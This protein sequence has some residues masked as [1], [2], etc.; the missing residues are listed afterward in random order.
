MPIPTLPIIA[1]LTLN[2]ALDFASAT[3]RVLHTDKLR[4]EAGRYDPGGGGL[5]VARVVTTL[6]GA[7]TAIYPVG[8]PTGEML[9]RLVDAIGIPQIAIPIAGET[10]ISF[11]VSERSSGN[12]YRFVLPGPHLT[13]E[14]QD[15][16]L[17]ALAMMK[18]RLA[19][20]VVSGSLPPGVGRD[21][22]V[23]VGRLAAQ[24]G[25][26]LFLDTSGPA[27]AAAAGIGAYLVKPNLRE[28][29]AFVDR[30]LQ[31]SREQITAGREMLDRLGA[32]VVIVSL[33]ADGALIVTADD[34]ECLPTPAVTIRS[35]VGAGDSM[36]G[37]IATRLVGGASLR[38]AA[39]YGLAAGAAALLTDG[40]EL[41]RRDDTDRLY[42]A[43][44]ATVG[45]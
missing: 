39:L 24:D 15:I 43:L 6:G 26:R 12:Q 23:R 44:R 36:M 30:P 25:T 13:T 29:S 21:F 42:V 9:R 32:Q 4:C 33:G 38:D 8:G 35:S 11:T 41:C 5:N 18:P 19:A 7:A 2:P 14:E 45:N 3:D 37:G 10:R 17:N 16:C 34:A 22:L 28:L 1:T 40:T 31:S 27:L 20:I